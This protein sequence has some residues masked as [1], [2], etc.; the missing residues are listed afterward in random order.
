VV[1]VAGKSSDALLRPEVQPEELQGGA[2]RY[3]GEHGPSGGEDTLFNIADLT[4]G[5]YVVENQADDSFPDQGWPGRIDVRRTFARE[6]RCR[7]MLGSR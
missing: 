7:A 5:T 1:Y 3:S 2:A 4:H 6:A